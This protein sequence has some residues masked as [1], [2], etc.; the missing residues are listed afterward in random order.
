MIGRL[1]LLQKMKTDND[2]LKKYLSDKNLI[3]SDDTIE[4]KE[5]GRGAFNVNH[6]VMAS[7]GKNFLFRFIIWSMRDHIDDM[8]KYESHVLENL[9]ELNISPK[10]ILVDE[11]RG[12]FSYPL[13]IEEYIDGKTIKQSQ[14]R[15]VEQI[16]DSLPIVVKLY[17]EGKTAGLTSQTEIIS[18]ELLER[19][20]ECFEKY[21]S[22]LAKIISSHKDTIVKFTEHCN[23]LLNDKVFVHGDLNPENYMLSKESKWYLVDWQSPFV[24]D[25]SFD[26]ATLLWDFYWK[27]FIGRPLEAEQ[28]ELIKKRYCDLSGTDI[29]ELNKKIETVTVF[30]DFDMLTRIEYLLLKLTHDNERL[31]VEDEE[32]NFIVENRVAPARA[33]LVSEKILLDIISRMN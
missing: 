3:E 26:I 29:G 19:K 15:F 18:N 8:A 5:I 30:L 31:G 33:L 20:L 7:S 28:K 32:K 25:A 13:I 2:L 9:S 23:D 14:E 10:L 11:T 24:G 12:V 21:N 6:L 17:R 27:F 16:I 22:P 4:S 1:K